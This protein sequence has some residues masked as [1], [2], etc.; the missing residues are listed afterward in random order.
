MFSPLATKTGIRVTFNY[1]A[2]VLLIDITT[3]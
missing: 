2:L 1:V 3:R